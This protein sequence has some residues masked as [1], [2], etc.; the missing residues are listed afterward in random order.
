M[1]KKL[2]PAIL[3]LFF[4]SCSDGDLSVDIIN[5]DDSN[6]QSCTDNTSLLFKIEGEETLILNLPVDFIQNTPTA[7]EGI[8]T[9]IPNQAQL[10]YRLFSENVTQAFFCSE[11]P[12]ATPVVEEEIAATDGTIS[13]VAEQFIENNSNILINTINIENLVLISDNGERIIDSDFNFGEVIFTDGQGAVF[14]ENNLQLCT[15]D[16][17]LLYN[18]NGNLALVIDLPEGSLLNQESDPEGI[19]QSVPDQATITYFVFSDVIPDDFFCTDPTPEMPELVTQITATAG[20]LNIITR[21][22]IQDG[23]TTFNH[24]ISVS[25]LA[26]L[27]SRLMPLIGTDLGL[28]T[29]V[30]TN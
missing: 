25:N 2:I 6:I 5:F 4:T 30:T 23:N 13:L 10:F 11:I 14:N 12:P 17:S 8:T 16:N 21:E 1:M 9:N 7:P 15:A 3:V 22:V 24:T 19:S 20:S 26:L 27:N 18:V 28:G 29:V